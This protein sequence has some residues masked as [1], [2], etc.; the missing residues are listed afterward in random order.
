MDGNRKKLTIKDITLLAVMICIL[1][2]QEQIL[3]SLPG[4]QL[5]IFLMILYS[6]KFGLLKSSI[7]IFIYVL[8]DNIYMNS[9]SLIYTPTMLIGW[10]IIPFTS[11]TIFKKIENTFILS[12]LGILY[13]FIYSIL[14]TIPTYIMYHINPLTYFISD[15][16]FELIL[17]GC[18]FIS[19]LLLYK[20]CSK[21]IEMLMKNFNISNS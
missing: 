2:V 19:I 3:S 8:L 20:P 18:S 14:Y 11:C 5:T 17:A 1:F 4:I 10:L 12:L 13:A 6:K 15:I 21:A 7:I 16:V 9:F